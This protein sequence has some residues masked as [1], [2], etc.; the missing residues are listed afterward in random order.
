MNFS[1][2]SS[3]AIT[4]KWRSN[5][6][7]Q[8]FDINTFEGKVVPNPKW[9][10]ADYVSV[11][12]GNPMYPVSHINKRFIVGHEFSDKRS[13]ERLF[14]VKSKSN[15]KT[16]NVIS[17]EGFVTCDC[18]GFQFRRTCRHVNKVKTVL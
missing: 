13:L 3:V 10:D 15:G 7:G 11:H 8:E 4:T 18:A 1:V 9:L 16:Y 2:G 12:T 6:L 17:F 14:K 5:I